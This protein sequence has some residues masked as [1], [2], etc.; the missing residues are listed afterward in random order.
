MIVFCFHYITA[1]T[2]FSTLFFINYLPFL[3]IPSY[4]RKKHILKEIYKNPL[5][6]PNL[7]CYN[8][9]KRAVF[10]VFLTRKKCPSLDRQKHIYFFNL[11]QEH[12]YDYLHRS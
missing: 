11:N 12:R 8:A 2:P 4:R 6:K 10:I 1:I 9:S 3:T 5:D 7:V